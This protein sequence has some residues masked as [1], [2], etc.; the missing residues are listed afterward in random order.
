MYGNAHSEVHCYAVTSRGGKRDTER[1]E[2]DGDGRRAPC[3]GVV[4]CFPAFAPSN[5]KQSANANANANAKRKRTNERW[6][7]VKRTKDGTK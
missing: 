3:W 7:E 6:N 5:K 1:A 4:L 2:D